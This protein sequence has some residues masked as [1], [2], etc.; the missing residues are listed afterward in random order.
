MGQQ[1]TARVVNTGRTTVN[2]QGKERPVYRVLPVRP[3]STK[4]KVLVIGGTRRQPVILDMLACEP[5][6]VGFMV[7]DYHCMS[8][9]RRQSEQ[10]WAAQRA[11]KITLA[12][13]HEQ[14][15]QLRESRTQDVTVQT[16]RLDA[17]VK[18]NDGKLTYTVMA[19]ETL[20]QR[21]CTQGTCYGHK[22]VIM[23][24]GVTGRTGTVKTMKG[25]SGRRTYK[26]QMK[27]VVARKATLPARTRFD[28]RETPVMRVKP[29]VQG[30][31]VKFEAVPVSGGPPCAREAAIFG[32]PAP[33]GIEKLKTGA[34]K[35][36]LKQMLDIEAVERGKL[37]GIRAAQDKLGRDRTKMKPR[38]FER[39]LKDGRTVPDV[40]LVPVREPV[41]IYASDWFTTQQSH[42]HTL[43]KWREYSLEDRAND[44]VYEPPHTKTPPKPARENDV[45][46]HLDQ[47]TI[48][49]NGLAPAPRE[50]LL[51]AYQ[52]ERRKVR[53]IELRQPAPS[54]PKGSRRGGGAVSVSPTRPHTDDGECLCLDCMNT[55]IAKQMA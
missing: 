42:K 45:L 36:A 9:V 27:H 24:T 21:S 20:S 6:Q 35:E 50:D 10:I 28:L 43:D 32:A 34:V 13:A 22:Y 4:V 48:E 54:K 3:I 29:T 38:R 15:R 19:D 16:R 31:Q 14:E 52:G 55:F 26:H 33:Y 7:R 39:K 5:H 51:I 30:A 46:E 40:V 41:S 49:H 18:I 8:R 53:E 1:A 44:E 12:E 23:Q 11:G 25:S 17:P 2:A 37:Q 47:G